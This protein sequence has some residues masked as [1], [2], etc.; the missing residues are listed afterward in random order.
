MTCFFNNCWENFSVK[1]N[2]RNY[3]NNS[4]STASVDFFKAQRSACCFDGVWQCT[5]S[6]ENSQNIIPTFDYPIRDRTFGDNSE[7]IIKIPLERIS[8]NSFFWMVYL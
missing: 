5:E 2:G 8:T 6:F 4:T 3:S 1:F 7:H